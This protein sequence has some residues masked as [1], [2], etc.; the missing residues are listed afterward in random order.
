MSCISTRCKSKLIFIENVIL[1]DKQI[2]IYIK[3]TL[4]ILIDWYCFCYFKIRGNRCGNISYY[5]WVNIIISMPAYCYIVDYFVCIILI[6]W[7]EKKK[8]C[9]KN[10]HI[11]IVFFV[12]S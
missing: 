11:L 12:N 8:Y 4:T 3:Y 7:A 6:C 2:I 1:L 9:G 10:L 5:Y